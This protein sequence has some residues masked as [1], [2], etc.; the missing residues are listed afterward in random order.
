[1]NPTASFPLLSFFS[2]MAVNSSHTG[3]GRSLSDSGLSIIVTGFSTKVSSGMSCRIAS[4][5]S[6]ARRP[7]QRILTCLSAAATE[8]AGKLQSPI[9]S[10]SPCPISART[11][12]SSGESISGIPFK[13]HDADD[14]VRALKEFIELPYEK[15]AEMGLSGR[16]HVEKVFDRQIVVD[17]YLEEIEKEG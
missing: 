8:A 7:S 6:A 11:F 15:K 14:L 9:T 3:V 4:I 13:S 1:M 2:T 12:R 17:K 5:T 10:V 16:K